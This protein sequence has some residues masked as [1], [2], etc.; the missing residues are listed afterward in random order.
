MDQQGR[1]NSLMDMLKSENEDV[2][3]NYALGIEYVTA[4][5]FTAA[6]QQF[7][8]VIGL[9]SGYVA[10]YYQLGKLLETQAKKEE[11]IQYYR[12]GLEKAQHKKDNKAVN[13]FSEAIFMLED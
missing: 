3:L 8:K 10:A 5:N 2:F 12:L 11:A 9:N 13:E 6:Y 1:I 4:L 7:T